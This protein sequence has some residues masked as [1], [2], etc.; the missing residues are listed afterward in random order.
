[1]DERGVMTIL[2]DRTISLKSIDRSNFFKL[3]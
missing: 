3:S 2:A 1:M